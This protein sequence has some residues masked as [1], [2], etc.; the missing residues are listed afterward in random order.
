M[1]KTYDILAPTKKPAAAEGF[2]IVRRRRDRLANF[3][4]SAAAAH[5]FGPFSAAIGAAERRRPGLINTKF[6][7]LS[8]LKIYR[9]A[10]SMV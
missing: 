10:I 8:L 1:Y 7:K 5:F 4:I 9:S 2:F 6:C 3:K